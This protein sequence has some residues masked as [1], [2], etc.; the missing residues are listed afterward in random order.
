VRWFRAGLDRLGLPILDRYLLSELGSTFGFGLSAFTLI[1]AANSILNVGRLVSQE[2]APLWAAVLVFVWTLPGEVVLVIP[3]AL[4]L[5]TL[6]AMQRLSGE[7]EITAMKAS[8]I[9]FWRIVAPFLAAGL[10]MS[11]VTYVLQEHVV[12]FAQDQVSSI[13]E[14]VI[15]HTSVF[16]RD[17][18]VSASLP[19]GGHQV[20]IATSYEPHSRALLNVTLVQYDANSKPLQV[21]FADRA[22][23]S[24]DKW[25]L[26]NASIY[27]FNADG[28]T[29]SEPGVARQQVELGEN[30]TD[31]VKRIQ[32]D[33]PETMSRAQ[34]A[35]II[36]T[37]QL[38]RNEF[39]KYVATYQE[40]LAQPFACFVFVLI[41]LPFAMRPTRG[42]GSVS[43]GFG[44]AV[45]IIFVYYIVMTIFSYVGDAL[46]GS[47]WLWAWMPNLIFTVIGFAR[48]KKIAAV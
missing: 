14:Q 8:G 9:T 13:E 17:L 19:G 44:L 7:S 10:V 3:M 27:R 41:A 4:L 25:I 30:P 20:T 5:G 21:V 32:H 47:A 40:K 28:T 37:G 2:G 39:Q 35:E 22:D 6:L 33:D 26:E 36:K 12:P 38:T 42:G 24:A 15:S 23:F 45:A 43:L 48:L 46:S 29:I 18:T 11:A 34:I 16:N 1:L 31:I